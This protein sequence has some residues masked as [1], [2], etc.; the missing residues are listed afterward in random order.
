[1]D[2]VLPEFTEPG[3]EA[4]LLIANIEAALH[5]LDRA[6]RTLDT[7]SAQRSLESALD[8]YGSVKHLLPK[9]GLNAEQR[10]AVEKRLAELRTRLVA[11][12]P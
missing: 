10:S 12:D 3:L 11:R 2:N 9:L 6:Q 8:T 1:M 7:Q 4:T 5:D